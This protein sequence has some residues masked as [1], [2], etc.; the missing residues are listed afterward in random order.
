ML[1]TDRAGAAAFDQQS[2]RVDEPRDIF[3]NKPGLICIKSP[4]QGTMC[5]FGFVDEK[6]EDSAAGLLSE[7]KALKA[8]VELEKA[9]ITGDTPLATAP[10]E[11]FE[12]SVAAPSQG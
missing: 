7:V 8:W 10:V 5:G 12:A 9:R 6:L 4:K 3:G 11:Q 1:P 2:C